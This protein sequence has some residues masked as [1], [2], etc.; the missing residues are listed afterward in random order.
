MSS[1]SLAYTSP[2]IIRVTVLV[3][4]LVTL[5]VVMRVVIPPCRMVSVVD[6]GGFFTTCSRRGARSRQRVLMLFESFVRKSCVV[7]CQSGT[8][9]GEV[10][11]HLRPSVTSVEAQGHLG[12][13]Q[14]D[15]NAIIRLEQPSR[16]D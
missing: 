16:T 3:V 7:S 9:C 1:S 2:V 11:A 14:A 5:V 13:W 12:V 15:A 10:E 4:V 6:I 8:M